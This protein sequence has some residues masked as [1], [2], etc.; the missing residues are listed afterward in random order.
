M[1]YLKFEELT[2]NTKEFVL[3]SVNQFLQSTGMEP[4]DK[5]IEEEATSAVYDESGTFMCYKRDAE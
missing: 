5:A 1:S 3:D 2:E 4:S